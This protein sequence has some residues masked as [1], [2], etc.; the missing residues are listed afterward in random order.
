MY[1]IEHIL[2]MYESL[3]RWRAGETNT[4]TPEK[5]NK[6]RIYTIFNSKQ[7]PEIQRKIFSGI[8]GDKSK[9]EKEKPEPEEK[10][11]GVEKLEPK[12]DTAI[13]K[14]IEPV[15]YG[16]L[17]KGKQIVAIGE[18]SHT[19]IMYKTEMTNSALTELHSHGF[20]ILALEALNSSEKT[21]K[22]LKQYADTEGEGTQAIFS[23]VQKHFDQQDLQTKQYINIISKAHSLKMK[24]IGLDLPK[25]KQNKYI[26][27]AEKR[28]Q[29]D[30]NMFETIKEVLDKEPEAKIVTYTGDSHVKNSPETMGGMLK[31]TYKDVSLVKLL[32]IRGDRTQST[33]LELAAY[34]ANL[35]YKRFMVSAEKFPIAETTTQHDWY[36]FLP[37]LDKYNNK[38][39]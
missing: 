23:E 34:A 10:S 11:T 5:N 15:N 3:R 25:E 18:S 8:L 6:S 9:P 19:T 14:S 20:N 29:R 24:I 31:Q 13:E 22:L 39:K 37:P 12:G 30:S 7:I 27:E 38:T 35:H 4:T 1:D 28:R 21:K 17:A 16:E 2:Y 36:I 26:D 32:G 33:T